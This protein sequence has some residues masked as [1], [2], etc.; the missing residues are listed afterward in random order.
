MRSYLWSSAVHGY[1][2]TT[3]TYYYAGE[4]IDYPFSLFNPTRISAEALKAIP[5]VGMEIKTLAEIVLPRPRIK[6][7]VALLYPFEMFRYQVPEDTVQSLRA[8]Y[9]K[10]LLDYY[11]AF[12]F[13]RIPLDM[14]TSTQI[15]AGKADKYKALIFR[16]ADIVKPGVAE[17]LKQYVGNGGVL[18][19]DH[20][21]LECEDEFLKP[22]DLSSLSGVEPGKAL[23]SPCKVLF[24]DKLLPETETVKRS[25]DGASGIELE[26]IS[27]EVL[28]SYN[29]STPAVTMKKSGKGKVYYIGCELP[30]ETR[31]DLLVKIMKEN[32]IVPDISIKTATTAQF[33]EAHEFNKNGRTVWF[34]NN[35]GENS[36]I[37]IAPAKKLPEEKNFRVREIVSN[38]LI[39][40]P[41][42]SDSWTGKDLN[43]GISLLLQSQDPRLYLIEDED[44]SPLPRLELSAKHKDKLERVWQRSPKA[45]SRILVDAKRNTLYSKARTPSLVWLLEKNGF[46]ILNSVG[47]L[48]ED[49]K[50]TNKDLIGKEPLSEFKILSLPGVPG[51]IGQTR[52]FSD[53][54]LRTIKKFVKNGGGLFVTGQFMR[55]PHGHMSSSH[56]SKVSQL[57]GVSILRDAVSDPENHIKDEPR[58][59]TYTDIRK[60][61]LTTD[62]KIF[63]S[64]GMAPLKISDNNVQSLI[65]SSDKSFSQV[66][67]KGGIPAMAAI[68][69]GKGR[70][71]IMGDAS[72]MQPYML[73]KADNA[74]LALNIFNWLAKRPIEKKDKRELLETI[75]FSLKP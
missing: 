18:V 30:Y 51:G 17:K 71:V 59:V 9:S 14:T 41:S 55:G 22:I 68:E 15:L 3:I 16:K 44:M 73:D 25:S 48:G 64:T 52:G 63:Q 58:F 61:P 11:Q 6:G 36:E 45:K 21:S 56:A 24:K 60:S 19:I 54:E 34:L 46:Q 37:T 53:E 4:G 67:K 1:S 57:F 70:V 23:T 38:K 43:N 31:K 47:R 2:A 33:V 65:L 72:W 32:G 62:V 26:N 42:S 7:K 66:L 29:N 8:P 28:A 27:A 49:I 69:Y 35:W 20:G 13:S 74:Q 40:S 39:K 10:D 5:E 50:T 12:L 75:D